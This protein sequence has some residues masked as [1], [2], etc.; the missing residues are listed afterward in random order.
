MSL[1]K[2]ELQGLRPHTVGRYIVS[3]EA[4]HQENKDRKFQDQN[5]IMSPFLGSTPRKVD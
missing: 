2:Y 3:S 4:M 5:L 1:D